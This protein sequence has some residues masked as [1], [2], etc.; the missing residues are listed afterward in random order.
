MK[1]RYESG[2]SKRKEKKAR[3]SAIQN[4][5]QKLAPISSFFCTEKSLGISEVEYPSPNVQHNDGQLALSSQIDT[6]EQSLVV[7]ETIST[8]LGWT[9]FGT[10]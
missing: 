4:E 8:K 9:Y 5:I 2:A 1:R 3:D 6:D 10:K 7:D